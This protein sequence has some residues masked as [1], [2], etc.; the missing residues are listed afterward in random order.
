MM[1]GYNDV[2]M[3]YNMV[4]CDKVFSL[5]RMRHEVA[6]YDSDALGFSP[7]CSL[8]WTFQ[9]QRTLAGFSNGAYP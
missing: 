3:Y 7:K 2:I 4:M 5:M 9:N 8:S 6:G 1:M